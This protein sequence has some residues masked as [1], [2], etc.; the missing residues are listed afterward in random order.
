[1]LCAVFVAKKAEDQPTVQIRLTRTKRYIIKLRKNNDMKFTEKLS[2]HLRAKTNIYETPQ[3]IP[4]TKNK[5]CFKKI[6]L[7]ILA[8]YLGYACAAE[9][10]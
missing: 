4:N 10:R 9:Y 1:M 2:L 7:A 8:T 6:K 3:N 5:Y